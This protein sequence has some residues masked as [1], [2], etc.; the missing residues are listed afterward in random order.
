MNQPNLRNAWGRFLTPGI[1]FVLSLSA[2]GLAYHLLSQRT[3]L[4]EV[5]AGLT[6]LE[7]SPIDESTGKLSVAFT[8]EFSCLHFVDVRFSSVEAKPALQEFMKLWKEQKSK[9]IADGPD[10]TWVITEGGKK[11]FSGSGRQWESS[12]NGNQLLLGRVELQSGH[13]YQLLTDI[14]STPTGIRTFKPLMR[15]GVL[16]VEPSYI[17]YRIEHAD[18]NIAYGLITA[19]VVLLFLVALTL[20]S[21]RTPPALSF[22]LVLVFASSASLVA[23]GQAGPVSFLR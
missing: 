8:P 18:E 13:H 10:L 16:S 23:S 9:G 2:F 4:P 20:R 17:L 12:A 11:R 19:G 21:T 3:R 5:R 7:A 14:G 15:V 1:L 6:P 22:V